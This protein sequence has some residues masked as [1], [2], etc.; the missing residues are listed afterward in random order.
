M[1]A[2]SLADLG[3]RLHPGQREVLQHAAR[4]KIVNAGRRWG[5]SHVACIDGALSTI[6]AG[7][8]V[9]TWII[10]PTHAQGEEIWNKA[11]S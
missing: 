10:S 2:V 7:R 6:R 5:K 1:P 8:P 4:F 11:L 3:L 9:D